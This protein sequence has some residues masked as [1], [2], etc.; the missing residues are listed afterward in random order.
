MPEPA[1]RRLAVVFACA[2]L[3]GGLV[4]AAV[5][6]ARPTQLV[7]ASDARALEADAAAPLRP[8][9]LAQ[10]G[11]SW[12]GGP[13]TTSTGET[14]DVRVSDALPP[15]ATDPQRWAEFFTHL[16][17]G[18]E[19]SQLTVY[20]DTLSEVQD[21]CGSNALGCY[22]TNQMIVPGEAAGEVSP[23]EVIRH[24]YGHHIAYHRSNPPWDAID[25]GPKRWAS[26]ENVCARV[27]SQLAYPGDEGSHYALNPGEAWA[28][29]YRILQEHQA[30]IATD[31]W[32]I[33]SPIFFPSAAVLEVATEDVLQP[34]TARKTISVGHVFGKRVTTWWMPLATP[35]DGTLRLTATLPSHGAFDVALVTANRRTVIGRAQWTGQ[36][37]KRAEASICGQR[38]LFVRVTSKG[39]TGRVR[40]SATTP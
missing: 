40:I 38:S 25:W 6:A 15:D 3:A 16:T 5:H 1:L 9:R 34:W 29:T 21:V 30:G 17:H 35:L 27:S 19:I 39:S 28:E 22:G 23:E 20:V 33:V 4:A 11:A 36:R 14:V 10:V 2:L 37:V 18:S 31:T 24:E 26:A 32:R 13:T 8:S 12:H 7:V